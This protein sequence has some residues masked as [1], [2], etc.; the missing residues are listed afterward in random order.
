MDR[1]KAVR[2]STRCTTRN[3]ERDRHDSTGIALDL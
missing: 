3:P 2:R 1:G